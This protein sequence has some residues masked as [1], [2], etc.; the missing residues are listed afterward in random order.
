MDAVGHRSLAAKFTF[1]EVI[2]IEGIIGKPK[3]IRLGIRGPAGGFIRAAFGASEG[4]RRELGAAN[5]TFASQTQNT[6]TD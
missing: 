2:V 3:R 6:I 5:W 1:D 4:I